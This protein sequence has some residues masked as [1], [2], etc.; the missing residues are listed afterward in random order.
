M[1]CLIPRNIIK[2]IVLTICFINVLVFASIEAYAQCDCIGSTPANDY[3]G[4]TYR[5]AYDELEAADVVFIGEVVQRSKFELP[6][7]HQPGDTQGYEWTYKVK[8]A[9]KKEIK[10]IVRVR[11]GGPCI[12]DFEKG[13]KVLVYAFADGETLR[14]RF[15]SRTRELHKASADLKEFEEK[16]I[17]PEKIKMK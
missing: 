1:F 4:S 15:C 2:R 7:P 13:K 14:I 16:G 17:K 9:W 10:E 8:K 11:M 12:L 5:S 6:I 3:R